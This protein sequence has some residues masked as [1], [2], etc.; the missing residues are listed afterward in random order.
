VSETFVD[1]F[2]DIGAD[3]I[4]YSWFHA[5]VCCVAGVGFFTDA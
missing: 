4:D 2:L 1:S 5:K 3:I